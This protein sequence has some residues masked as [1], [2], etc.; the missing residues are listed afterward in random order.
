M[1]RRLN[2]L[3]RDYSE[4]RIDRREFIGRAMTIGGSF[5]FAM[6]F[7]SACAP[8]A[9]ASPASGAKPA[10]DAK[11]ASEPAKPA[12]ASS[13]KPKKTSLSVA[14]TSVLPTLDPHL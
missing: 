12:A 11:P 13:G 4:G 7:L 8:P 14:A 9:P 3:E 5:A 6:N 1:D 10:T 2:R